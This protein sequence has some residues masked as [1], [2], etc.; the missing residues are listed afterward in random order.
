MGGG[1]GANGVYG[2]NGPG[3]R[4]QLVKLSAMPCLATP[5]SPFSRSTDWL[6]G[7]SPFFFLF[8]IVFCSSSFLALLSLAICQRV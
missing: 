1:G 3:S 6:A 4:G 2:W 8:T 7:F 5:F